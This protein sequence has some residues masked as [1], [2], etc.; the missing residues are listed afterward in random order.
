M[1]PPQRLGDFGP[2]LLPHTETGHGFQTHHQPRQRK[3]RRIRH[4][5]VCVV[6]VRLERFK[7]DVMPSANFRE[8]VAE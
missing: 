7:N 6:K 2:L 8:N 5:Q 3:L 4:Q 1:W